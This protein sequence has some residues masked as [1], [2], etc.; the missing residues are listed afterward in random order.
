MKKNAAE[1]PLWDCW[2][3]FSL[4]TQ[5][6]GVARAESPTPGRGHF[7]PARC[8]KPGARADNLRRDAWDDIP[9]EIPMDR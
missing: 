2:A 3:T 5:L 7:F 6:V 8:L 4:M 9:P 1:P